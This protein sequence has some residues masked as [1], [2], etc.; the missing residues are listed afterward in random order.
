MREDAIINGISEKLVPP[1]YSGGIG[2]VGVKNI[3]EFIQQGGSLIT[4][5][6]AASF[7]ISQFYLAVE[8]SV[9]KVDRK[10]FYVPGSILRVLIDTNH[11]IAYGYEREGAVF[12]RGSPV[13]AQREGKSVVTYPLQNPLLSGWLNGEEYLH[14]RSA[15][16]D[17]PYGKGKIILIG[18]PPQFRGQAH[19]TFKFLFNSIYYAAANYGD[20][21]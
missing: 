5:N 20:V 13:F 4:L 2:E 6:G 8:N 9:E 1:E 3:K 21:P 17:M 14:N 12:F 7:P 16:V 10:N 18:F 19:G 11:P 15:L